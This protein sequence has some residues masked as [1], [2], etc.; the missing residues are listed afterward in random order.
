VRICLHSCVC[1]ALKHICCVWCFLVSAA[2]CVHLFTLSLAGLPCRAECGFLPSIA[3]LRLAM[4]FCLLMYDLPSGFPIKSERTIRRTIFFVTTQKKRAFPV[5]VTHI[6]DN[7]SSNAST[8]RRP[9]SN[10]PQPESR[11]RPRPSPTSS[12]ES[13]GGSQPA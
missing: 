13:G 7:C 8:L 9:G 6:M 5:C 1:L 3:L 10:K 2:A 11:C 12:R 4:G